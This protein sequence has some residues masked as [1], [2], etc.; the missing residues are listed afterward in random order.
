MSFKFSDSVLELVGRISKSFED[1]SVEAE[2]ICK[3]ETEDQRLFYAVVIE[4]MTNVT[5]DGDTH[6]HRMTEQEVE[7]SAHYF[8]E[9]DPTI[10]LQHEKKVAAKCIESFIAPI[11][12]TPDGSDVEIKKGSWVMGVKVYD[13]ETW[14]NIKKGKVTA[15]SPGGFARVVEMD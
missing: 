4:P 7:K 10:Y 5:P 2:V 1:D 3:S 9:M 14:E 8:M 11:S 13:D 6:G 15:F 12:F